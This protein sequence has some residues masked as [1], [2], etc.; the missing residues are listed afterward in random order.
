VRASPPGNCCGRTRAASACVAYLHCLAAL[1][2]VAS[3]LPWPWRL[4]SPSVCSPWPLGACSSPLCLPWAPGWWPWP[5]VV[6]LAWTERFPDLYHLGQKLG[7]SVRDCVRVHGEGQWEEVGMQDHSQSEAGHAGRRA[8]HP[9]EVAI[10]FHVQ[11]S[12]ASRHPLPRAGQCCEAATLAHGQVSA[13]RPP[14]SPTGRSAPPGARRTSTSP[15]GDTLAHGQVSAGLAPGAGT[16]PVGTHS[17]SPPPPGERPAGCLWLPLCVRTR[18]GE[19]NIV[20]PAPTAPS[21]CPTPYT[22]PVHCIAAGQEEHCGPCPHCP[23]PTAPSPTLHCIALH[24]GRA[25]RTLWPLPPLPLPHC[26]ISYTALYRTALWQGEKNIVPP[27]P[28]APSPLPHLLTLH[29]IA[30]HCG[31]ARRTLWPLPPLPLPHCPI[32]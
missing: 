27:A 6:L 26:P 29:C 10:L 13:A 8:G 20:A 31:R 9:P 18:Q 15:V 25:R 19:K 12:A 4:S 14:P 32:S 5:W 1:L 22:A 7:G 3:G 23:F 30:L 16:S 24:C 11:V 17:P 28:T 2:L 21:H